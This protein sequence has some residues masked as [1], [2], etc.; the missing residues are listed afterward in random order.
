LLRVACV[1]LSLLSPAAAR[2]DEAARVR[3]AVEAIVTPVMSRY[4]IPG[5]A[6]AVSLQGRPYVLNFGV[7]SRESGQPV[8]DRTLFE[9]GSLSKTLTATL[10]AYAAVNGKLSLSDSVGTHV[11]ALRGKPIDHATLLHVGTYTAGGLPLQF[12]D[13]VADR[14]AMLAWYGAWVPK[15][16]PGVQRQYSN[17]SLGLLGLAAGNALGQ[18]FAEA[19]ASIV[20]PAFGMTSTFIQVPAQAAAD[21]AWGYRGDQPVRVNPGPMDDETYGVKTTAADMLRFV[22]GNIDP[23]ILAGSMGKAVQLTHV[24][25]F[26][27]GPLLQ[28]LGWEQ[29]AYPASR[30][31]LLGGNAA[32][33]IL[34][35]QPA[36][37]VQ[38]DGRRPRLFNKTGSTGG[39]GAYALFVPAKKIGIV[40]LANRNYPNPARIEAAAALLKELVDGTP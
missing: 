40:M 25:H 5:M 22:Q 28:G 11:P 15:A 12:P 38:D 23:E 21:Y 39:F 36:Q 34:E 6:V 30:E 17:P 4:D 32:E 29:Y 24:G 35:A 18:P 20:F 9:I 3:A 27:A 31:W 16:P 7:A 2:A 26:R 13:A 19:M 8:T 14:S 37:A 10:A 1:A 33:M